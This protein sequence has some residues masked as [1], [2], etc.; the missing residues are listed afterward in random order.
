MLKKRRV[1]KILDLFKHYYPH[2]NCALNYKNPL[3]LLISTILSAQ[4][5]DKRVNQVTPLLFKKY[6]N[7]KEFG[8][9]PIEELEKD[10]HSTGFYKNKAKNIKLSCKKITSHYKSK[11][12]SSME[13]LIQLPGV[14]RKTANVVLGNA[15][16]ISSGLVVDTHVRR[17]SFRLGLTENKNP[18][19]IEKDLMKIIPRKDWI[20]FSHWM[21]QHGRMTCKSRKPKCQV[22]FLDEYC[23]KKIDN[24]P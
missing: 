3:Q 24:Q 12:P 10:I 7:A 23:P 4:C 21:I 15:F 18:D 11:V 16:S 8:E 20:Q 9:A 13:E 17:L 19:L 22:C 1:K 5:T 14:G 6:K 2:A